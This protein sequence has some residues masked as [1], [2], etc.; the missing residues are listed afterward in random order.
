MDAQC[1]CCRK[2]QDLPK[3]NKSFL[4]IIK[5]IMEII[6]GAVAIMSLL[7]S[8]HALSVT[9][10]GG[11]INIIYR[12]LKNEAINIDLIQPKAKITYKEESSFNGIF[13]DDEKITTVDWSD[14]DASGERKKLEYNMNTPFRFENECLYIENTGDFSESNVIIQFESDNIYFETDMF[15]ESEDIDTTIKK[16]ILYKTT[17]Y[18]FELFSKTF[19]IK[20][21]PDGYLYSGLT[22]EIVLIDIFDDKV[23]WFYNGEFENGKATVPVKV[24]IA[25]EK[26][27]AKTFTINLNITEE[28]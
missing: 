4:T 8:M 13:D 9:T 18:D 2:S 23:R 20:I 19:R 3:K 27:K 15:W 12:G 26:Y 21:N 6:L 7:V 28:K 24:T 5:F 16:N 22:E 1:Q 17:N 11:D 14:Y 10:Q 25:S